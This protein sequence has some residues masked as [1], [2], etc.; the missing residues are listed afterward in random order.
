[1]ATYQTFLKRHKYVLL[2]AALLQH[3]FIGIVLTDLRFYTRF[4]WPVNMLVLGL[5]GV[6]VF[7]KKGV[8]KNRIRNVL[9][10]AVVVLPL[11][12]PFV[13]ERVQFMAWLSGLYVVFFGFIFREVFR[14]LIRP[15]YIDADLISASA[16]GYFLLLE[17]SIFLMQ[18]L[19]YRNP[20]AFRG[21]DVSSGAATF[22]DMVYFCA[23]TLTSIGYGDITPAVYYTKLATALF[24]VIGQFYSVVLVGILISKFAAK[25]E[26][27]NAS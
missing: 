20:A 21:I 14:F 8:W 10:V 6:G 22:I 3:L 4:I 15:G 13:G 7:I 5:A 1:M 9:F 24:G 18:T 11:S 27:P 23:I 25:Q 12:L 19:F 16:C 17:I 2:L 26:S